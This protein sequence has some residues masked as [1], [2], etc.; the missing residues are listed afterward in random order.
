MKPQVRHQDNVLSPG[1]TTRGVAA[2][3]VARVLSAGV[4]LEQALAS[5]SSDLTPPDQAQAMALAYGALRWHH[6]HRRILR[7]LLDRALSG[8]DRLI[9]ALLSVGLFQLI[10]ERQPAYASVSAT[11]GAARWLGRDRATALVNA[12]LRRFQREREQML[13]LALASD[14]GRFAHPQWLIDRLRRDW[15]CDWAVILDAGQEAPPLWLRVNRLRTDPDI[16][17]QRLRVEVSQEATA[18]EGCPDALRLA[19]PLPVDRIPGFHDGLVSVQDA[20]SQLAA[21]LL[22]CEPGARVL[23]AC[24]APGGKATHLLERAGGDLELL[25]LD[26]DPD[27]LQRVREN[28]QRLGLTATTFAGDA[29]EPA[30]WWDGRL[31]DRI[32]VDAPCSGTGVIRRHPDI[33]HLR[34]AGDIAPMASRQLGILQAV[35]PLLRPGGLLLYA[36]CS[37]LREENGAVIERFLVSR[38]DAQIR[39]ASEAATPAWCRRCSEGGLQLLPGSADTDGLYYALMAREPA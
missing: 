35:W 13:G 20:G 8:K 26:V 11:V 6:R 3:A 2:A 24:A 16:Y 21:E 22:S 23:D 25:A 36:T 39:A 12:A 19:A 31:F 30:D 38:P 27:R 9:E 5:T 37:V 34:R 29:G 14:E 1:A 28:L 18:L 33:K 15:P 10:D 4:T 7:L 17:R 32:L